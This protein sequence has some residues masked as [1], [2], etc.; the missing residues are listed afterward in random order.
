MLLEYAPEKGIGTSLRP[1]TRQ[2]VE[3]REEKAKRRD[4]TRR[5]E[6]R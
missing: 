3:R 1:E 6:K 5:D 4:E 2:G